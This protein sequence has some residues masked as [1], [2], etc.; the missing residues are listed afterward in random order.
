MTR[1]HGL[2]DPES[3]AI[4]VPIFDAITSPRRGGPRFVDSG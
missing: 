2:L 3:A 1:V 4:V